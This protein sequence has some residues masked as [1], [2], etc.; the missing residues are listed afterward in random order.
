MGN[1]QRNDAS[2]AGPDT[3]WSVFSTHGNLCTV[4][5]MMNKFGF[6][7]FDVSVQYSQYAIV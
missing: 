6:R 3:C 2:C 5:Y 7:Q 1:D 4:L